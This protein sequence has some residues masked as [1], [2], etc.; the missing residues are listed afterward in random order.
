MCWP[1]WVV[2][3]VKQSF[4]PRGIFW[5][6]SWATSFLS[7]FVL[8]S[9]TV[10]ELNTRHYTSKITVTLSKLIFNVILFNTKKIVLFIAIIVRNRSHKLDYEKLDMNCFLPTWVTSSHVWSSSLNIITSGP[11]DGRPSI[12][13]NSLDYLN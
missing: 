9:K 13:Y 12:L 5:A 3:Y 1:V 11:Q 8:L 6:K 4:K 10:C 2:Q 7:F